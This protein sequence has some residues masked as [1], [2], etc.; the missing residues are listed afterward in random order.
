VITLAGPGHWADWEWGINYEEDRQAEL[1]GLSEE[2]P[3]LIADEW[4][5]ARVVIPDMEF[6][7]EQ[8]ITPIEESS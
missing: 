1:Q 8:H 2:N 6:P 5:F 3:Y 7:V 4:T